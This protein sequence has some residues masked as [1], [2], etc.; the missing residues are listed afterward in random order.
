M[1]LCH[2]QV[3]AGCDRDQGVTGAPRQL[4]P[5]DACEATLISCNIK[6]QE[7]QDQEYYEHAEGEAI[8]QEVFGV[9]PSGPEPD[10]DGHTG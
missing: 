4:S 2:L 7:L 3:R 8:G 9:D 6:L 1:V 10:Q 5:M